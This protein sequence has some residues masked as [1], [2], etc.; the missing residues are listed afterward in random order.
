[1]RVA[2]VMIP[3]HVERVGRGIGPDDC[4]VGAVLLRTVFGPEE[5]TV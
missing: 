3:A 2:K 4:V 5:D 1:M